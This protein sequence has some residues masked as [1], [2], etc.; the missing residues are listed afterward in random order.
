MDFDA[1]GAHRYSSWSADTIDFNAWP[2]AGPYLVEAQARSTDDP[3]VASAW[4]AGRHVTVVGPLQELISVPNIPSG[5]AA[6]AMGSTASYS[7]SGAHSY[8]GHPIEYQFHFYRV[9]GDAPY[10]SELS[11]WSSSATVSHAWPRCAGTYQVVA[12]ARCAIHTNQVSQLSSPLTVNVTG[13]GDIII[14]SATIVFIHEQSEPDAG[15]PIYLSRC[16][17]PWSESSVTWASMPSSSASLNQGVRSYINNDFATLTQVTFTIPLDLIQ[18][19][20]NDPGSNYGLEVS[21]QN[22]TSP[23]FD[24]DIDFYERSATIFGNGPYVSISWQYPGEDC[25]HVKTIPLQA[26]AYVDE[27]APSTNFGATSRLLTGSLGG[28]EHVILVRFDPTLP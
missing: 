6:P 4:S 19:W 12:Q 9:D 13:S 20:R 24:T 21:D 16:L 17:G 2:T 14:N 25:V 26:D 22:A 23:G 10:S 15:Q 28:K 5:D 18:A 1:G 27:N 11:G 7:A 8:L 3:S